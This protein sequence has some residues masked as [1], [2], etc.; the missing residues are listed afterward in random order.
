MHKL[1]MSQHMRT[2]TLRFYGKLTPRFCS[3]TNQKLMYNQKKKKN[4]FWN[5]ILHYA[6][7]STSLF[8]RSFFFAFVRYFPLGNSRFLLHISHTHFIYLLH[9][10][11][12]SLFRI[13]LCICIFASRKMP[14]EPLSN[15]SRYSYIWIPYT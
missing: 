7:C 2:L 6:L 1:K 4:E 5:K 15:K 14:L 10:Y 11:A 3:N 13:N 8:Q 9:I 12:T